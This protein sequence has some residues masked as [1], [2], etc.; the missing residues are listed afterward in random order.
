MKLELNNS[1][2]WKHALSFRA[3]HL[4]AVRK[5]VHVLGRA[6]ASADPRRCTTWRIRGER[7]PTDALDAPVLAHWSPE[8]GWR[9][10]PQPQED[11]T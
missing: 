8:L 11:P 4:A 9:D 10:R 3:E 7:A 5:A 1:G 2:A 6:N